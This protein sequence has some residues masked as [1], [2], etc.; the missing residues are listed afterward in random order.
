[1]QKSNQAINVPR[2]TEC[3]T[4]KDLKMIR[5][6]QAYLGQEEIDAVTR[7]LKDGYLG[8]GQEVMHFEKELQNYISPDVQ[9]VCVNTGTSALQLAVQACEIGHGDEVIVPSITY[10]ASFQAVAATGAIPVACDVDHETGFLD[11]IDA[12]RRLSSKTKAIMPVHYGSST[13]DLGSVYE[14]ARQKG[15]RVIED[16]A[17]S[18]GGVYQE[19]P[20]GAEG[21]V[22]C[23]SFDGIK[24]ITCGEGGAIVSKDTQVIKTLQDL[25]LLGV[26]KDTEK[27]YSGQR[28]W[29]FQ[30]HNQ[31]WRYHMSNI[32]ASIGREQLKKIATFANI[33][34]TL[35]K[36]YHQELSDC[37]VKPI[38]QASPNIVPHIFPIL[39]PELNRDL[40]KETL[41]KQGVETGFH[42]KPNHLLEKFKQTNCSNAERFG[43][44]QLTLPL[45]CHLTQTDILKV[46]S[47]IK[48]FF[49]AHRP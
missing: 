17:H 12:Q 26:E 14:F 33:R 9:V 27:R 39:V 7:V 24:N 25:R 29:D 1:M 19:K 45:H 21:D 48:D 35:S 31:G 3:G 30:V 5:L 28:S 16:A 34:Q 41:F 10:V 44:E 36:L 18:F 43:N 4:Y 46:T 22:I 8:M 20:V 38:V 23:F 47:M 32:N 15:L 13:G 37:P 6:S 42:Y 49:K 40:L 2:A 11:V